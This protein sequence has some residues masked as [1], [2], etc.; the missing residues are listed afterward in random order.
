MDLLG[1]VRRLLPPAA[2]TKLKHSRNTLLFYGDKLFSV[3]KTALQR[4]LYTLG[5]RAGDV[6]YV[7][8]SYDDM[9]SIRATPLEIIQLLQEAVGDTGTLAMP[10][11]PM[12][13]LSQV[14]L[15]KHPFFDWRRTP[16]RS[17]IITEIFRRMPG[18]ERS[19]HPTH[20]LAARGPLAVWLTTGHERSE[21]PFDKHS[22]FYKL[23]ECNAFVL[24]LGKFEAMTLRHFAD[25]LI[26]EKIPYPIYSD[27][28]TR[29]RAIGKDGKEYTLYTRAHNPYL[30][31]DH[32][33][34]LVRLQQDGL[35]K[36]IKVGRVP[37]TLVHIKQY[38]EAYQ[39]YYDQ[40]LFRHYV[41]PQPT[42]SLLE[43]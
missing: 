28:P 43:C 18:T 3:D 31:C 12:E 30:R 9:R 22:P 42:S 5:I 10:T 32:R 37:V 40:G 20:P 35:L 15:D 6:M 13:G 14:Y 34:V 11:Y 19:L 1:V 8:S 17:G 25:H 23:L 7:R 21:T 33:I 38:V 4:A 2:V 29:V 41:E 24:S 39:R 16:S 36:A 26:Q 27:R